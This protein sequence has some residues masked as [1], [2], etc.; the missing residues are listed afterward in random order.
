[1]LKFEF[2]LLSL[3]SKTN[4][5]VRTYIPS[6]IPQCLANEGALL[7]AGLQDGLVTMWDIRVRELFGF[8]LTFVDA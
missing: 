8:D 1:M 5:V 7:L 2:L 6:D 3:I 4:N